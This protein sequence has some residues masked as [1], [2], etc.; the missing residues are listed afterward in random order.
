[1]ALSGNNIPGYTGFVPYKCEFFGKTTCDSN[2]GAEHAFRASGTGPQKVGEVIRD[3]HAGVV[4]ERSNAVNTQQEMPEN[5]M[6][7][8]MCSKNSKT[9]INGPAHEIRN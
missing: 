1:M 5:H 9:W 8:G 6:I 2:R 7:L 4:K 3:F